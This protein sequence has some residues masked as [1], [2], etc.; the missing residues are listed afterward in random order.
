M[1][2]NIRICP[3]CA[4]R[5]PVHDLVRSDRVVPCP[6][7]GVEQPLASYGFHK[8]DDLFDGF[9]QESADEAIEAAKEEPADESEVTMFATESYVDEARERL[10]P[11]PIAVPG[12][13]HYEFVI[14]AQAQLIEQLR[15]EIERR[16]EALQDVG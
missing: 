11:G 6:G 12:M 9:T 7:C 13:D 8:P 4:G 1:P 10:S 3:K 16:D 2:I 5:F 14:R 15:R